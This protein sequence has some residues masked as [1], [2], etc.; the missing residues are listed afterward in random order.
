MTQKNTSLQF[1]E[2]ITNNVDVVALLG[3]AA[4]E[5]CH[6]R[7]EKLKPALKPGYHALCSPETLTAPSKYFFGDD[8]IGNGIGNAVGS[9]KHNSRPVANVIT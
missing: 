5:L 8:L 3:H 4:H 9:S 6:L 7:R 1:N 2:V